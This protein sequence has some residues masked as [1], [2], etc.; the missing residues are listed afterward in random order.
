MTP[1]KNLGLKGLGV[2]VGLGIA[3]S[4][5]NAAD[6]LPAGIEQSTPTVKACSEAGAINY[7]SG[8]LEGKSLDADIEYTFLSNNYGDKRFEVEG[9]KFAINW[10]SPLYNT[11][12]PIEIDGMIFSGIA[13]SK[14][15][16]SETVDW[17]NIND[18]R[19]DVK[20][21]PINIKK[22]NLQLGAG[23]SAE[24]ISTSMK[25]KNNAD[26][27]ISQNSDYK[28]YLAEALYNIEKLSV[29]YN[30]ALRGGKDV[31]YVRVGSPAYT[32]TVT[33]DVDIKENSIDAKLKTKWG[34]IEGG[35]KNQ[36]IKGQTYNISTQSY[37][38]N[39]FGNLGK[40]LKAYVGWGHVK[41]ANGRDSDVCQNEVKGGLRYSIRK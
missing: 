19:L 10:M 24:D 3:S 11:K 36:D 29:K 17:Y 38:A 7:S 14:F 41:T 28:G 13:D 30:Y 6:K 33:E 9:T 18:K 22:L 21:L 35:V 31:S 8:T 27:F 20:V 39:L 2:I 1:R 34:G 4:I 23:V 26:I 37:F 15:N 40:N 5:A 25:L 32:D 12:M 16:G